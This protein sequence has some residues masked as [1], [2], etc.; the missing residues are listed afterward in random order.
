[1]KSGM[2]VSDAGD[3][4]QSV[5]DLALF[6]GA[7]LFPR[8]VH[9]GRPNIG[10]R[11]AILRR[12]DE[13]LERRWLSN[14][15]PCV[16]ELEDRIAAL[17]G[18]KHVICACNGTVALEIAIRA[19]GL[20]GEVIIPSFTFVATAHALQWQE[21]TPVFCDID[22]QTYNIDPARIESLITPRTTGIIGVHVYGRPC[23]VEALERVAE[24]HGLVLM[25]DSAHAFRCT[26]GGRWVGGFGL[27]EI[28][29]FHATKFF[30]T[31]EGGAVTTNDDALA[32]RVRLMKNFGFTDYDR[33]DHVGT[34]GKMNEV[35]AAMGMAGLDAID[36]FVSVNLRNYMTYKEHLRVPGLTLIDYQ[37]GEV[38]NYQYVV[39][40][41][42]EARLGLSRDELLV[43]LHAENILARRYFYPGCHRME[44]YRSFF[45]D[46]GL[47]L[48]H[49]EALSARILVLPTGTGIDEP[50]IRAICDFIAFCAGEGAAIRGRGV[51]RGALRLAQYGM[52]GLRDHRR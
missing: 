4:K 37:P 3:P 46:A 29:S 41:V 8:Q 1:M 30:N 42:D 31:L 18:V 51:P 2:M 49:T 17:L 45:P 23:N 32:R 44:P 10:D 12:F 50:G 27:A 6:G 25:F 13:V 21:I 19:A 15:G 5:R 26:H 52:T 35:C 48:P 28:L 7:S 24:R 36:T 33:V 22:P 43:L 40:E 47:N 9:V 16:R 38:H 20:R 39:A 34:N 11:E 14:A